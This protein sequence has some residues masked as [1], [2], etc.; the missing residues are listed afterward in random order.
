MRGRSLIWIKRP[1]HEWLDSGSNPD[2]PSC[3]PLGGRASAWSAGAL[4]RPPV[5]VRV[6]C[7]GQDGRRPVCAG[8]KMKKIA[9]R[10]MVGISLLIRDVH[11]GRMG[12][13]L[14]SSIRQ[15]G[16]DPAHGDRFWQH[17]I[18]TFRLTIYLVWCPPS[19]A[20]AALRTRRGSS[21]SRRSG[22]CGGCSPQ[23]PHP[24][25]LWPRGCR[26]TPVARRTLS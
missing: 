19:P 18:H 11:A 13:V 20:C 24:A 14:A 26:R 6:P 21:T 16:L 8:R 25:P 10:Q 15:R 9:S 1:C 22:C 2:G 7:H 5:W 4:D 23:T 17:S 3:Q 12:L